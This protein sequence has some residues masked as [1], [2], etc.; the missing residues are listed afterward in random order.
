MNEPNETGETT[1]PTIDVATNRTR[2]LEALRSGDYRQT[3]G[4]LRATQSGPTDDVKVFGYCCLGVVETIR[5]CVWIPEYRENRDT[6]WHVDERYGSTTTLS[7]VAQAW[8]GVISGDPHVV[9]RDTR[10]ESYYVT[11]LTKLND[12]VGLSLAEIA[13]VIEGQPDDWDGSFNHASR[14]VTR[15]RELNAEV[16]RG[17]S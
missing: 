7:E 13:D 2:V 9:Y 1:K 6:R 12:N 16:S 14:E 17:Q 4:I 8:L 3:R 10:S 5:G 11:T 15:R